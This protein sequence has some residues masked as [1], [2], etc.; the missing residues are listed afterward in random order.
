MRNLPTWCHLWVLRDEFLNNVHVILHEFAGIAHVDN[1]VEDF[2]P[3]FVYASGY[4]AFLRIVS[5]VPDVLEWVL[6]RSGDHG[7]V[8]LSWLSTFLLG[9]FRRGCFGCAKLWVTGKMGRWLR[10]QTIGVL[11]SALELLVHHIGLTGIGEYESNH[12]F[13]FRSAHIK[14]KQW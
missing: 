2:F 7:F 9:G 11:G 6:L 10:R 4:E 13:L 1:T 12:A 5:H 8:D 14:T 3:T